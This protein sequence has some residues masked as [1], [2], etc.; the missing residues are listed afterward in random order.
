M[1]DAPA[2]GVVAV[3]AL[4][5][6]AL[7][8]YLTHRFRLLLVR[9][10][11]IIPYVCVGWSLVAIALTA[12]LASIQ[13]N[14]STGILT[15]KTWFSAGW[16]TGLSIFSIRVD[17]WWRYLC[18]VVYQIVRAFLGSL[19]TNIFRSYLV[20]EVQVSK[21]EPKDETAQI[22]FAQLA[23][24][25]FVFYVSITDSWLMLSQM[26]MTILTM[27]VTML[28][29]G[30]STYYFMQERRSLNLHETEK[31]APLPTEQARGLG[32]TSLLAWQGAS[33]H[34]RMRIS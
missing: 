7:C 16:H 14:A 27:G 34:L 8:V 1:D 13:T 20:V 15:T 12:T 22:I 33:S 18:V 5:V 6:V 32:P 4:C 29:D 30:Q 2:A 3:V 24:D 11:L 21:K 28:A 9:R 31:P 10:R 25:F 17:N 26:D 19:I 23:F